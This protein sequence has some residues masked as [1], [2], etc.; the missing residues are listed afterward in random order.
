MPAR[1]FFLIFAGALIA[2]AVTLWLLLL[3]DAGLD[4]AVLPVFLLAAG[5]V[6]V[7]WP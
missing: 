6:R 7:L 5:T 3:G 4:L 1:R 2:A